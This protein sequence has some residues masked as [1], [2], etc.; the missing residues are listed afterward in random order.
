MA[1]RT[2]V[3]LC[4][5]LEHLKDMKAQKTEEIVKALNLREETV[6]EILEFLSD[7]GFLIR[8]EKR[9]EVHLDPKLRRIIEK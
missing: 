9:G 5:I 2:K 6:S 1:D 7:Y 4:R 8:D 3:A